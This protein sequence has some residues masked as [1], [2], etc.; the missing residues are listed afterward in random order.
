MKRSPELRDL[1]E[2]HHNGLVAARNLRL[3]AQGE[4]PLDEVVPAFLRQWEAEIQPHFRAEEAVLLPEFAQAVASEDPLIT[5]ILTEHVALRRHVLDLEQAAEERERLR[6]AAEIGRGLEAH[7]RFEERV[8]FPAIEAAL[9][10][11]PLQRLKERLD[12]FAESDAGR[13]SEAVCQPVA[14][15]PARA[16]DRQSP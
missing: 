11:A 12:R 9:G 16:A 7:I 13:R 1:S 8:L 10:G 14:L 2:E 4:R 6:L 15:S 3:A 5:R